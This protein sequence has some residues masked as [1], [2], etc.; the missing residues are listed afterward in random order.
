MEVLAVLDVKG[1]VVVRGVGGRREVYRPV[2]SCLCSSANPLAVARGFSE[3]LGLRH[4]YVA[5]L[6]G[7]AGGPPALG[8]IGRL[9][10]A[11]FTLVVDA[12]VR[13][14]A[15][16]APLLAA[17]AAVVVAG[18]ETLRGPGELAALLAVHGPDRVLFS[19]D[20][21]A[22]RPMGDCAGWKT[23]DPL[24]IA[25]AA[26]HLGLE[27]ILI[28][29]LAQVGMGEGIGT[30]GLFQ[31]LRKRRPALRVTVGGGVRGVA[32]LERL[33]GLEATAVLVA[34]AF[35]DGR[36]TAEDLRRL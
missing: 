32:D 35:H 19:L 4:L 2:E 22:G 16:A 33:R 29:D 18:L 12:G 5:D 17:G 28:L 14:A 10:Q 30:E 34:S 1:G 9:A 20:L 24:A 27:Q 23:D 3:R 13:T 31:A 15:D 21:K 26:C 6:D 8:L 36:I 7:L 11:G 25:L